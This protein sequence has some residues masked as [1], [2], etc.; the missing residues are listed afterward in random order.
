MYPRSLLFFLP[1]VPEGAR[2]RQNEASRP[3]IE[4]LF[5][6]LKLHFIDE[7]A[8]P[9]HMETELTNQGEDRMVPF[10]NVRH[11]ESIF[12]FGKVVDKRF[13]EMKAL[14]RLIDGKFIA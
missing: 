12:Q 8:R 14:H 11:V 6:V 4:A 1:S 13:A 3:L 7:K 10:R 5:V 2:N 9:H